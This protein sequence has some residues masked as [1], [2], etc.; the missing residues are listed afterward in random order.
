MAREEE[1][2]LFGKVA[3]VTG[4]SRGIGKA[5][6]AAY[7]RAGASV[8]ICARNRS[9]LKHAAQEIRNEGGDVEFLAGDIA[10]PKEAKQIVRAARARY[11]AIHILVNNA[12]VLGPRVPIARY[13]MAA[14]EQVIRINLTA[15]FIMTQEVLKTMIPARQGSIINV[16]SGVGRVGRA[17]WAP[18]R[19]RS[20]ASK[21]S[22]KSWP[23]KF[24]IRALE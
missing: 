1:K 14:W 5:V 8:F 6:A 7:A 20:S 12:S 9:R 11:G 4:G 10:K 16:S 24:G 23:M 19:S 2:K 3:L 13:P 18:I 15:L 21:D 22:P 17:E